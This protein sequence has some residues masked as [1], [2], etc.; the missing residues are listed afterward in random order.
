MSMRLCIRVD[1]S[2][3]IGTGHVMRC[4]TLAEGFQKVGAQ[5][6]FICR[7]HPGHL[8]DHIRQRGFSLTVLP[9]DPSESVV[10]QESVVA[11]DAVAHADWLGCDWLTDAEQTR[12]VL[13]EY[14]AEWLVVDHY[15]LDQRWEHELRASCRKLM[16]IDD[17]AD[18]THQCDLLLDQN[19]GRQTTD[20]RNLVPADCKPLLGPQYALLRPEF[21]ALRSYSLQRRLQPVLK[22]I[23]ITMGG[24]DQPNATGRILQTLKRCILPE[25]CRITVVMGAQAP[26]L[27]QVQALAQDMPW[28]T[29][30]LVSIHDMAQYMA[31]SD[32]AIGAAGGTSWERCCLGLPSLMNVLAD[33]QKSIAQAL[34]EAKAAQLLGSL[35][36]VE[37][38]LPLAIHALS[39]Q[40]TSQHM[41]RKMSAAAAGLTDGLGL[42]KVL[43]IMQDFYD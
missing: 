40:N 24:V 36:D 2:L 8:L 9:I 17:L 25:D 5:S 35:S 1:A 13:T 31:D 15:A 39:A 10:R 38:K 18:R 28:Q 33:N 20:Y 32:L 27:T 42:D 3:Q 21:A 6:H 22:N 11:S 43:K 12:A 7:A 37:M 30:V 34:Q 29:Q 26:W 23:L 41:L 16:V 14:Q 4:L 19:L